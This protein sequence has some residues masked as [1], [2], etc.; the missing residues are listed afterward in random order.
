MDRN[1]AAW[2]VRTGVLAA[3]LAAAGPAVAAPPEVEIARDLEPLR[4][5]AW[6]IGPTYV[7]GQPSEE[8]LQE[9]ARRGITA[10]ISV[11]GL[12][13]MADP[14]AVPFDEPMLAREL[15]MEYVNIPLG[16]SFAYRPEVVERVAEVMRRHE[17]RVL[18][19]CTVGW[20]AT[21]VFTA[22]QARFGGHTFDE[23]VSMAQR[24][25]LADDELSRLMGQEVALVPTGRPL[26][27]GPALTVDA[28]WL[29]EHAGNRDVRVL[30]VRP[31]YMDYFAGHAPGAVHL[32][33]HTL[34]GPSGGLPVQ[35]RTPER[36]AEILSQA[37]VG[38][39]DRV[40]VYAD[41]GDVLS[42][43]MTMYALER[44]G[45][46]NSVLLDGGLS[47]VT[48]GGLATRA[49]PSYEPETL[50]FVDNQRCRASLKDVEAGLSDPG[51][52][53]VD[54]RPPEQFEGRADIWQRNGHIPGAVNVFWRTL[55]TEGEAHT[56]R[57]RAEIEAMFARAGVTPD[58]D[59]VVYCGTSREA[60]LIYM[61]LTRELGFPRVRV[62]EGAWTEYS[63]AEHLPVES[64][65]G[66]ARGG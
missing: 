50:T 19:H 32:D 40:V 31:K 22:Y 61:Y 6:K 28:A 48:A 12:R 35:Y 59:V 18:L 13:E 45:Y 16:G 51:V 20:R 21:L 10:V 49:Y 63:A 62:F 25:A 64:G 57:P 4:G 11:R 60:T 39:S 2:R 58:R 5:E 42:A 34:R 33:A 47:A 9:L 54:A 53:F 37:G 15:G 27:V 8:Q 44:L 29:R 38:P 26:D 14:A 1:G 52:L 24:M 23:A 55:L 41:G 46:A 30:D 36:M 43:T 56:L 65:P 7:T 3:V 66:L 17:G